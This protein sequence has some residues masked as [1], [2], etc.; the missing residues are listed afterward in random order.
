MLFE[1]CRINESMMLSSLG[2]LNQIE[3][4]QTG[5]AHKQDH[6]IMFNW[7]A[8]MVNKCCFNFFCSGNCFRSMLRKIYC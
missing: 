8:K 4:L 1:A 5:A 2:R 7:S 6:D 3:S